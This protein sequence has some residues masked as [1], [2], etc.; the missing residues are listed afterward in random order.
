MVLYSIT[1]T[2]LAVKLRV[3]DLGL[4]SPFYVVDAA[5]DYSAQRSAQLLKLLMKRGTD[6]GYFPEPDKSLFISD[7][8]VQEATVKK[9]FALEEPTLNFIS[10]TCT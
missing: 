6:R 10:G 8:P 3:A 2:P 9:E 1:L 7:T 4:V 5:F